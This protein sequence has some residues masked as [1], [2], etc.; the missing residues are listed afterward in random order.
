L[1][2]NNSLGADYFLRGFTPLA[3][4]ACAAACSTSIC[5]CACAASKFFARR[6]NSTCGSGAATSG[7]RERTV[8]CVDWRTVNFV[9]NPAQALSNAYPPPLGLGEQPKRASILRAEVRSWYYLE[10]GF[11]KYDVSIF[12]L[13]VRVPFRIVNPAARVAD[14]QTVYASAGV[15]ART[16]QCTR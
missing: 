10:E 9:V 16:S 11:W 15:R 6:N 12:E 4:A 1:V 3:F 8:H 14:V 5:S 13:V 7:V 2:K